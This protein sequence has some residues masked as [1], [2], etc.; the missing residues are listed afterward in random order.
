MKRIHIYILTLLS[1][2]FCHHV[3]AQWCAGVNVEVYGRNP[4]TGGVSDWGVRATV[5]S[6]LPY[7]ITI[8]G[9]IGSSSSGPGWPFTI[10]LSAGL[11]EENTGY[12]FQTGSW[13]YAVISV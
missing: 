6:P 7:N 13:D 3:S 2:F 8:Y 12:I 4:Q 11:T 5:P 1:L 9:F 10:Y